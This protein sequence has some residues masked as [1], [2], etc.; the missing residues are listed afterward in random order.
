M[1]AKFSLFFGALL[2]GLILGGCASTPPTPKITYP[3]TYQIQIGN[4]QV[5]SDYGPQTLNVN[6]SQEVVVEPNRPLYYQVVSPVDV[7]VYVYEKS[8]PNSRKQVGQMEGKSF[9]SS[10]S[11]TSR[12]LEFAFSAAEPNSSGKVLF[13]LSDRPITP[14]SP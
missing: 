3:V 4:T 2:C 6:A 7:T 11:P 1:H 10:I 8:A 5:H 13:T 9:T 12:T 14:V